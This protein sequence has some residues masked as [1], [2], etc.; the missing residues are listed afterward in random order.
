MAYTPEN[1]PYMP[2]DPYS[3]D[4]KWVVNEIDKWKTTEDAVEAA[5]ASAQAA[6]QSAED[7]AAS[8]EAAADSAQAAAGSEAAAKD[9]A[10]NIADPVSGLVTSWLDEHI[11]Q[12]TTPAIDTSLTVAGAAAD[13]KATGNA[14]RKNA[15]TI[16]LLNGTDHVIVDNYYINASGNAS[17]QSVLCYLDYAPV[18]PGS[19]IHIETY[20]SA[21]MRICFYDENK[22]FISPAISNPNNDLDTIFITD[23][24]CPVNAHY[25]RVSCSIAGK[26]DLIATIDI[27]HSFDNVIN[28]NGFSLIAY[29]DSLTYGSG[30][31]GVGYRYIDKCQIALGASNCAAYALPGCGTK[32]IA[33]AMGA[34][35]G[36]IPPNVISNFPLKYA[37]LTE[38][39]TIYN[40]A[41]NNRDVIIDGVTYNMTQNGATSYSLPSSYTPANYYKPVIWARARETADIYIIWAGTNGGWNE[42]LIDAM[43]AKLPNKQYIIMGLTR[44]GVDTSIADE[45]RAYEKYGSHF[46]NT[47]V[48]IINNAFQILGATPTSSDTAAMAAGQMPPSL[49]YDTIHFN[50]NG[51]DAIGKLL[52]EHIKSLNYKYH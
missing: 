19:K 33:F 10:D 1:N 31:S 38:D 43:I 17:L 49:L 37:D 22:V 2:G 27:V 16:N 3:Y 13:A 20:M 50:D 52:A 23:L 32:A 28:K 29:G 40:S 8:A 42:D 26:A 45:K 46:F 11:T 41:F 24:T 39:I 14:I 21:G 7:A 44:L 18:I 51:Y 5:A 34:L 47:R 25:V 36:F 6:G 30:S 48:Q 35:S 9:Y 15:K 4:L 12:P